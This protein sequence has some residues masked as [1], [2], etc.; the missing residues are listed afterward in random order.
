MSIQYD[1]L[2]NCID[3]IKNGKLVAFPTE[4]VYGLGANIFNINAINNIYNV[5]ERP[6]TDPLIVHIDKLSRINEWKLVNIN[7][8]EFNILQ[9]INEKFWPGP[10]TVILK[11]SNN[12]PTEITGNTGNIGIRIPDSKDAL[13]LIE[14]SGVPIAAPSA[15]K[16]SHISPTHSSHVEDDFK[17]QQILKDPI[18]I[19]ESE[20]NLRKIGIESTIVKINNKVLTILRPGYITSEDLS[21]LKDIKIEYNIKH[22]QEDCVDNNPESSGQ[23]IKHYATNCNTIIISTKRE[24]NIEDLPIQSNIGLIDIGN[25]SNNL[26]KQVK[27][28]DNLSNSSNIDESVRS[29]YSKLRLFEKF[30]NDNVIDIL[31]IVHNKMLNNIKYDSLFDR[32]YRS[33]SGNIINLI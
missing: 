22:I 25:I 27:Y 7:E 16:F 30:N 13:N 2:S 12:V 18:Y 26:K 24:I 1:S 21:K 23:F 6:T 20:Y 14:R 19:L 15:N 9:E 28:Y 5:K 17:D 32:I 11:A 8:I 3:H 29:Y 4:T 33:A 10:I 31:Y